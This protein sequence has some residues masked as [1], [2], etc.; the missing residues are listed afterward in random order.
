M[1]YEKKFSKIW[2]EEKGVRYALSKNTLSYHFE[3]DLNKLVK[4]RTCS[5][6][7][8]YNLNGLCHILKVNIGSI[9]RVKPDSWGCSEW[10][11][12]KGGQNDNIR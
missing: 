2:L 7:D 5:K 1:D 9:H 8:N 3:Q 6:C 4:T 12:I 10:E 11:A